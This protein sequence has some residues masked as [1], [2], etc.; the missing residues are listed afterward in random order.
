[1][2]LAIGAKAAPGHGSFCILGVGGSP[3]AC[4]KPLRFDLGGSVSPKDLPKRSMAPVALQI[5]GEVSAGEGENP[6]ALHMA[7]VDIDRNVAI[8]AKGLPVCSF[9]QLSK[10]DAATARRLCGSSLVGTGVAHIGSSQVAR[11]RAALGF[12]NAGHSHG[13]TTLL[14]QAT[15]GSQ[16]SAPIVTAIK[17]RKAAQ[18][19]YG[20][21][22]V[23]KVP[24]ILEGDGVVLDFA[25]KVNRRFEASGQ[26]RSYVVARCLDGR[27]QSRVE[28]VFAKQ[29]G[30]AMHNTTRMSGT[31][32]R[33]CTI[34]GKR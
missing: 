13:V 20:W 24:P 6:P 32:T 16:N 1:M 2:A 14:V 31:L 9:R 17:I 21:Q 22:A 28:A 26:Q 18:G 19:R 8:E 5:R 25:F 12:F 27:L 3:G 11:T 29:A 7:T 33:S 15:L 30:A 34:D 23:V 10:S 4:P